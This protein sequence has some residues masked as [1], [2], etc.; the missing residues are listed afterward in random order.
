[1]TV[2]MFG[3]TKI[4]WLSIVVACTHA[5]LVSLKFSGLNSSETFFILIQQSS[6]LQAS[7]DY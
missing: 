3:V 6:T 2:Y 1:M 5:G 4:I 7:C